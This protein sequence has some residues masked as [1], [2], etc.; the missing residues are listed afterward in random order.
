MG[1][2]FL[3]IS[4]IGGVAA[5]AVP[6]VV[7]M[8]HRRRI[9]EVHW[10]AN[11]LLVE[12]IRNNR[13]RLFIDQWLLLA[14][15]CL[16][17]FM[18]AMA[19]T[20]PAF[21][22]KYDSVGAGALDRKGRVAA[23]I[24]FDD[25]ASTGAGRGISSLDKMKKLAV[26]YIDSLDKGDEVS[27]ILLS[28]MDLLQSDPLLDLDAAR[29]LV[30]N[31]KGTSI[32]SDVPSLLEHGLEQL[33]R[34]L[35]PRGEIVLVTDGFVGGWMPELKERWQSIRS[36]LAE[37]KF[38]GNNEF[39]PKF[40]V[41]QPEDDSTVSNL[42]VSR[43]EI[44]RLVVPANK[45]VSIIAEIRHRGPM[46]AH[47]MWVQLEIDGRVV[48]ARPFVIE[49]GETRDAAFS[50]TF[51]KAGSHSIRVIINGAHDVFPQDDS[52]SL[53]FQVH[54]K[55]PVLLVD[56]SYGD[57]K[58]KGLEFLDLALAPYRDGRD[59]FS[60]T[61]TAF[62]ELSQFRLYD[63]RVIILG[64]VEGM[65]S[66][67]LAE[68][69]KF[70][71][72]GGGL[73]VGLGPKSDRELINR[74]W[75]RGGDG[76]LPCSLSDKREKKS[77][78]RIGS[79]NPSY[80]ALSFLKNNATVGSDCSI[81]TYYS[82][83]T[84]LVNTGELSTL[85][86][87]HNGDPLLVARKRG[88][89]MCVL[90]T[91]SL[92]LAWNDFPLTPY[93][94]AIYRGIVSYLASDILPPRNLTPGSPISYISS[95]ELLQAEGPDGLAVPLMQGAWQGRRAYRSPVIYDVGL[96]RIQELT[97]DSTVY[98]SYNI[99]AIE[100]KLEPMPDKMIESLVGSA[101]YSRLRG[102]DAVR[103]AFNPDE[104]KPVEFWDKLVLA[105]IL[106]LFIETVVSRVQSA[107]LPDHENAQENTP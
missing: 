92:D 50:H 93:Y 6:V 84:S 96:Y 97:S 79:V 74:F 9:R 34:H 66:E 47:N 5:V 86:S 38:S 10:G 65:G 69:E 14:I 18:V 49:P 41:L 30:G 51:A 81:L 22:P 56:G 42:S 36:R 87:L 40:I 26:A 12:L 70:V 101:G 13:R 23:V 58:R 8:V 95:S 48:E 82:L 2:D 31:I 100:S 1:F 75:A 52:R 4:L 3:N 17:V 91:T 90:S 62:S 94:V 55:I 106:L 37:S 85:L 107:D 77:G 15:R 64:D 67:S 80:P 27:V 83:D 63:Y 35:I 88:M 33:H 43:I 28:Q 39:S 54:D 68:L 11:R 19:L 76:F 104:R 105:G 102:E 99:P 7:H 53:S 73:L 21:M 59:L 16:A 72:A 61:R 45:N 46:V 20:R 98:F 29:S 78:F 103:E 25:S 60:I 89:G 32:A 71:V 24:L 57:S 44:N